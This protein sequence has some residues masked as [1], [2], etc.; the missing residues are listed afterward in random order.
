M[1]GLR[2]DA[3]TSSEKTREIGDSIGIV[4]IYR[5]DLVFSFTL[6]DDCIPHIY[7]ID[8]KIL[9]VTP[10]TYPHVIVIQSNTKLVDCMGQLNTN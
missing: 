8:I 2:S 3:T 4:Y 10:L 1:T 7:M 9:T 5:Y 6:H